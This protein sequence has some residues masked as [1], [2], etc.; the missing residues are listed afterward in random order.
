MQG[1]DNL[2]KGGGS[3]TLSGLADV[4]FS[5]LTEGDLLIY[6]GAEWI[7]H[8]FTE[9]HKILNE[10][11][12]AVTARDNLQFTDGLKVTDDSGN[13]KTK[14]GVD[15]A[16]TEAVTRTNI[17]SGDS[18]STILGKIK[19]WFSDLSSM[20]VS[21][22][23]DTMTGALTIRNSTATVLTL[24]RSN[25]TTSSLSSIL[26]LG[27]NKAEG[28]TG[29]SDGAIRFYGRGSYYTTFAGANS[30]ANRNLTAPDKSGTIALTSDLP[31]SSSVATSHG[32][33]YR[34]GKIRYWAITPRLY[35]IGGDITWGAEIPTADCPTSNAFL[36]GQLTD[37]MGNATGDLSG[38]IL[39]NGAVNV[40]PSNY[41]TGSHYIKMFA[42]WIL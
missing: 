26:Y 40:H 16:F 37:S 10:S 14:V 7:N 9:G 11:G 4:N 20:F 12:T 3:S 27:N 36:I 22:T 2:P 8:S 6:D 32:T 28:T 39:T 25:S 38:D 23:G 42:F 24:D 31:D 29:C 5:S 35:V 33:L 17:A 19:K 21:K 18:F 30:T 41:N 1:I 13:N 15:T 34:F